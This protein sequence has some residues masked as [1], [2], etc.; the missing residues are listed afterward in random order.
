MCWD[1]E[2]KISCNASAGAVARRFCSDSLEQALGG[3]HHAHEFSFSMALVVSELTTN[4]VRADCSHAVLNVEVHRS[5]LRIA[6]EDDGD[7]MPRVQHPRPNERHGRGLQIVER[8]SRDWGV[9][10][11]ATGK[12]VWVDLSVPGELT[13]GLACTQPG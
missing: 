8:V 9:V 3:S 7:G 4:A 11:T 5:Y 6:V 10:T 2:L 13:T 1:G 12:R